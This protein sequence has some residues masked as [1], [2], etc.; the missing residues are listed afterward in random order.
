MSSSISSSNNE[1]RVIAGMIL[2]L[3]ACESFVRVME[4]SISLDIRHIR[5]M[6]AIVERLQSAGTVRVL[7]LGNS[8]TRLGVDLGTIR[9][10][11]R[12]GDTRGVAL[13]RMYPDDTTISDWYYVYETFLVNRHMTPELVVV[14]FATNHL[15]DRAQLHVSRLG[16]YFGGLQAL[17]EAFR[18]DIP[19]LEDRIQ[20]LLSSVSRLFANRERI[21]DRLLDL[22][23]PHYR[24]TAQT[25]NRATLR[26][27]QKRYDGHRPTYRRL[28][29]F[30]QLVQS[31][32]AKLA[33][34]AMPLASY[35]P[36]PD[37]L[38]SVI[39]AEDGLL[40]DLRHV[41]GLT[42]RDFPDRYHLSPAGAKIYSA[43]LATNLLRLRLL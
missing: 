28:Q 36:I 4:G 26:L 33:L 13:E 2:L 40:I 31:H 14:G 35:Y 30:M 8:L 17:P 21:R 43:A 27:G 16:G 42:L 38:K 39:A 15:E 23:L 34:V 18:N 19:G 10:N 29:R 22:I 37:S 32:G 20:Y 12:A 5:E 25:L 7:F 3:I 1:I 41:A 9:E 24:D 11:L 6:P